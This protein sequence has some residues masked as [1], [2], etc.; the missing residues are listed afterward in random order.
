MNVFDVIMST[1]NI[2]Y[3][4]AVEYICKFKNIN[5]NKKIKGIQKKEIIN[6]DWIF[7][8]IYI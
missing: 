6:H 3:G 1:K 7:K 2:E 5:Y 4:E 8:F